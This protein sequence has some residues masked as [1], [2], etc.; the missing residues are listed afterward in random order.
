MWASLEA[1]T[2]P[3][4]LNPESQTRPRSLL[5]H[6][7]PYELKPFASPMKAIYETYF[8]SPVRTLSEPQE[9]LIKTLQDL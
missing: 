5:A 1:L 3:E 9:N 8:K 4:P 2:I 6:G 7:K